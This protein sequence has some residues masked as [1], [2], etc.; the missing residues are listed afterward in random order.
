MMNKMCD[1]PTF[2]DNYD[3]DYDPSTKYKP[4][5]TAD[6]Q[7]MQDVQLGKPLNVD[8]FH[9]KERGADLV[10]FGIVKEQR[11]HVPK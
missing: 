10:Q 1:R 9:Y 2:P 5:M 8:T 7:P 4:W 3:Y 11:W 6:Y